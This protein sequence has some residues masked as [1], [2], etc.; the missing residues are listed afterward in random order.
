MKTTCIFDFCIHTA[1]SWN[2]ITKNIAGVDRANF[3]LNNAKQVLK[4]S[5]DPAVVEICEVLSAY[6]DK[7]DWIFDQFYWATIGSKCS[8]DCHAKDATFIKAMS[9]IDNGQKPK[10]NKANVNRN[11][12]KR[13]RRKAA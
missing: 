4:T 3:F 8:R 11:K 5:K 6:P 13:Q 10:V 12:L 1:L 2:F 7:A 9:Q